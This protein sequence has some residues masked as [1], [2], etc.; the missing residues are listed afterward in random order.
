MLSLNI[1]ELAKVIVALWGNRLCR[2][3]L[4]RRI[5]A[6]TIPI[7]IAIG[8]AAIGR[9]V[10]TANSCIGVQFDLLATLHLTD[11]DGCGYQ[12]RWK[13]TFH[14]LPFITTGSFGNSGNSGCRCARGCGRSNE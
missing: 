7:V 2:R 11:D 1:K 8:I 6:I 14:P 10:C 3:W 13:V 12:G 5:L 9:I 4:F